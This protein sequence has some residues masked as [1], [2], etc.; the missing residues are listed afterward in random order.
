MRTLTIG[1]RVVWYRLAY[2]A[3]NERHRYIPAR[4]VECM[5]T[6]TRIELDRPLD[7][8][9]PLAP[10]I[11]DSPTTLVVGS[12]SLITAEQSDAKALNGEYIFPESVRETFKEATSTQTDV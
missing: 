7:D 1:Q 10:V 3:P 11:A 9:D 8:D 5:G 4:V 12:V 6:S 2:L